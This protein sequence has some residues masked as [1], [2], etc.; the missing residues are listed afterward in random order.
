MLC[1][2]VHRVTP[3]SLCG[4][5]ERSRLQALFATRGVDPQPSRQQRL[6]NATHGKSRL[7]ETGRGGMAMNHVPTGRQVNPG[8]K[9]H[10]SCGHILRNIEVTKHSNNPRASL[11][12]RPRPTKRVGRVHLHVT[13]ALA[14]ATALPHSL[15][16][17]LDVTLRLLAHRRLVR[18]LGGRRLASNVARFGR[19]ACLMGG[20]G[21]RRPGT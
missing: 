14:T 6:G 18:A 11:P 2:C 1:T 13:H 7:S 8:H 20:K 15:P 16:V 12:T 9:T 17:P 10:K 3:P 21:K 19:R 4:G 5:A